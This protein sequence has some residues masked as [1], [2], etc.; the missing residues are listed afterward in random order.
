MARAIVPKE[1]PAHPD[2]M[3][4]WAKSTKRVGGMYHAHAIGFTAC[5]SIVLDRF[6]AHEHPDLADL[7]YWGVCPRCFSLSIKAKREAA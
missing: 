2:G 1:F 6:R 5:R 7:K 4:G 3:T